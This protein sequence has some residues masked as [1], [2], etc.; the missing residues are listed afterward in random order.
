[1]TSSDKD[2][3]QVLV[4]ISIAIASFAIAILVIGASSG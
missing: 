3:L 4:G 1:M 2:L